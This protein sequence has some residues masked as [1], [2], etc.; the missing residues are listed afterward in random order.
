M[1][2]IVVIIAY[3]HRK[4]KHFLLRTATIIHLLF[5]SRKIDVQKLTLSLE[6]IIY[7]FNR[8]TK[9]EEKVHLSGGNIM[10]ISLFEHNDTAYLGSIIN[11]GVSAKQTKK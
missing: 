2:F 11:V 9:G 6:N 5:I 4:I 1:H 10:A 3:L 7:Y 8:C